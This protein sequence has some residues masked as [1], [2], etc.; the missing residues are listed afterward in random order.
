MRVLKEAGATRLSLVKDQEQ[1][2]YFVEKTLVVDIEFQKKLFENE[3]QV[4]SSLQHRHIIKFERRNAVNSFFM[5]YAARGNLASL[6]NAQPRS[7]TLFK[8]IDEF[9]KGLAYLHAEGYVHNDIK[10]SNILLTEERTKLS[11]FAFAGKIGQI[12]FTDIPSYSMIGTDIYAPQNRKPNH[13]NSIRDDL[14]S[15]GILLYQAFSEEAYPEKI[16]LKKVPHH[17]DREIVQQCLLGGCL[18]AE[19]LRVQ[20]HAAVVGKIGNEKMLSDLQG[21][22]HES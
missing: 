20:L 21:G 16:D 11:D 7:A 19:T 14:Y 4:H 8:A 10:P 22:N 15:C 3:I 5:E 18:D 13:T 17:P 6:L 9:L 12:T 2:K 1:G